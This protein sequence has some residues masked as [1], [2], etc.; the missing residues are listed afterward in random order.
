M[1]SSKPYVSV[2]ATNL[3]DDARSAIPDVS[4]AVA[5]A[6]EILQALA[7]ICP[8]NG[9]ELLRRQCD[10]KWRYDCHNDNGGCG[11][12]EC[13]GPWLACDCDCHIGFPDEEPF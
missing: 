4:S 6:R 8:I 11:D 10:V 1:D 9:D 2:G 7:W 13:C 12:D 3:I 5:D